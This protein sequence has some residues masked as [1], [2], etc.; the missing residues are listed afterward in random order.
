MKIAC[1]GWGSLIWRPES[2]KI[3][4]KWFED[5]PILPIEFT[6][7]S[8]NNRVTLII[9][10]KAKPV[11]TL[12]AIMLLSNLEACVESLALRE[13]TSK[14]NIQMVSITDST[15]D[16]ISSII[17]EWLINN[18]L[19]AAIWTSLSFSKKTEYKRPNI[20]VILK[21]LESLKGTERAN[22]EE[23][24]RKAPLQVDTEYR[25]EIEARFGWKCIA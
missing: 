17:K 15:K 21:H 18:N 23:Y 14:T 8:K 9:D 7:I 24:I 13:G 20:N 6:R 25:R 16:S 4:N 5:G 3:Q 10:A 12:W 19:D 1:I 22:A 2:L 11:R